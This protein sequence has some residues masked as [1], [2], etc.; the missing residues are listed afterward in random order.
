MLGGLSVNEIFLEAEDVISV[1][2]CAS[3]LT[4]PCHLILSFFFFF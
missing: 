1:Q 3:V 4:L 2:D